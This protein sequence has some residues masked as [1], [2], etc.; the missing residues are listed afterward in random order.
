MSNEQIQNNKL[1]ILGKLTASLIHEIR[2]PLS[3]IKLNLDY[4]KMLREDLPPEVNES[5]DDCSEAAFR[6]ETMVENLL[7]FSRRRYNDVPV[8]SLTAVTKTALDILQ[9]EALKNNV[10]LRANIDASVNDISF[11][12][13]KLLQVLINLI[14]NAMESCSDKGLVE[15]NILNGEQSGNG[16]ILWVVK[17]N[18]IGISEENKNKIF[19]DF[20]TSKEKG[21]G[22]GLSV[23]KRLLEE[24]GADLSFDSVIGVGSTFK[25]AFNPNTEGHKDGK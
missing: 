24:Y 11:D 5:V 16:K 17:D 21:T 14:T 20:Y 10:E 25:I 22:L 19:E 7:D 15:I 8:V 1:Q 4:L 12:K 13:N 23:C 18:G 2:N 9:N 6:I 3:A